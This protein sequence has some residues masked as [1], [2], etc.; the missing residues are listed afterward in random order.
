[1]AKFDSL[2]FK[3][4]FVIGS[5][6]YSDRYPGHEQH[7]RIV[8]FVATEHNPESKIPM[9]V[10]TGAPWCILVPDLADD[11]GLEPVAIYEPKMKI[12]IRGYDFDGRLAR[13]NIILQATSG[14]N[15]R[16]QATFFIPELMPDEPW[17]FPNFLG[18]DGFLN[19]IR[20]A[21]DPS[22]NAFYFGPSY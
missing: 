5:L 11:W 13:G 2:L 14:D 7:A 18:L 19:R 1:M 6:S 10:D 15:L 17:N 3:N 22:E 21:V 4:N 12:N 16:V 8:V 9:I 20:F